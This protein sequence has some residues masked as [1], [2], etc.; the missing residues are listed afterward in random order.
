MRSV[1]VLHACTNLIVFQNGFVHVVGVA[2]GVLVEDEGELEDAPVEVKDGRDARA[3]AGPRQ[4]RFVCLE[5][6]SKVYAIIN[7]F[8]IA[9]VS[10]FPFT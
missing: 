8:A 6:P 3:N 9:I 4:H 2:L 7:R 10:K 1:L 5:K